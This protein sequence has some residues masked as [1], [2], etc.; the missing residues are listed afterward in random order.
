[1][2]GFKPTAAGNN[3]PTATRASSSLGNNRQGS[4]SDYQTMTPEDSTTADLLNMG[5]SSP[6]RSS[7]APAGPPG[8]QQSASSS[9]QQQP[10]PK[11]PTSSSSSGPSIHAAP[12]SDPFGLFV[13]APPSGSSGGGMVSSSISFPLIPSSTNLPTFRSFL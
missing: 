5:L 1:M 4:A 13:S 6:K 12:E 8:R 7:P 10:P 11:P 2:D 9:Q 3:V